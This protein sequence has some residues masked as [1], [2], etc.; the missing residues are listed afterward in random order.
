M[1]SEFK[2]NQL[3]TKVVFDIHQA[4]REKASKMQSEGPQASYTVLTAPAKVL[5]Q[6]INV[7]EIELKLQ[8]NQKKRAKEDRTLK[9]KFDAG[10]EFLKKSEAKKYKDK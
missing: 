4:L 3:Q 2:N 6:S 10:F 9:V 1:I 5:F 7:G 8:L